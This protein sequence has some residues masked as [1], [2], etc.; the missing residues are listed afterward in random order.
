MTSPEP[1]L[2]PPPAL[3][4]EPARDHAP[5]AADAQDAR[6]ALRRE[7]GLALAIVFG[8]TFL[9]AIVQW[10]IPATSSFMQVG[11]ALLLLE[12]PL[13]VLPR[14][15]SLS[16]YPHPPQALK[17]GPAGPGLRLGLGTVLLVF[18]LFIGGFHLAYTTLLDRPVDW[19]GTHLLRWSE[20]LEGAPPQPCGRKEASVWTDE[21]RLWVVA[22]RDTALAVHLT[23]ADGPVVHAR[24]LRCLTRPTLGPEL[25]PDAKGVFHPP[26]GTGLFV[27]L[28]PRHHFDLKILGATAEVPAP[29]IRLGR[30]AVGGPDD[31]HLSSSRDLWWLLAY[32]VIH[33]GLVAYPEES[34]FRGY[35][36][37]RLDAFY[38]TPRRLFGVAVGWGLPLSS[39]AFALLHPIL[40]PGPHRLLV[41]F[42]ALLFGWLARRQGSLGAAILVHAL[43]NV[44]LAIVSRMYG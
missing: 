38:G 22:P 21:G 35:L 8:G 12:V 7:I 15:P 29:E 31:G 17:L 19:S 4:P 26:R 27:D 11:L 43:S 40:I 25:M 16:P 42:P 14:V 18:P 9:L 41:F 24:E 34:F 33:L 6:R 23:S 37:P 10:I 28:G 30:A 1:P 5:D 13:R 36:L 32:L 20:D 44:C 3:A 2:E 39:L